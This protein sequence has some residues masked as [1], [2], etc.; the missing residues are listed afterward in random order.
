MP[1]DP[2]Q[3]LHMLIYNLIAFPLTASEQ[4]ITSTPIKKGEH[5][6]IHFILRDYKSNTLGTTV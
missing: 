6:Q 1:C 2:A 5:K 3:I 4:K